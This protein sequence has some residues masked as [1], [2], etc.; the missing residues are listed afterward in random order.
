MLFWEIQ[1]PFNILMKLFLKVSK[2]VVMKL[3]KCCAYTM[4]PKCPKC[5]AA[6][7]TAHP[8]KFS[9]SDKYAKYRRLAKQKL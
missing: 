8:P 6:A 2:G 4:Q 5:G 3:M 9:A 1:R 7:K